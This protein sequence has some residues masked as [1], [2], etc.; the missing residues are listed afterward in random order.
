MGF[1]DSV[2]AVATNLVN[3]A[4]QSDEPQ[5]YAPPQN[6]QQPGYSVAHGAAPQRA[7]IVVPPAPP[8]P[9]PPMSGPAFGPIAGVSLE[10]YAN[11]LAL[12][13]DFGEDRERCAAI[14]AAH[15]V[16]REAWETAKDG[17]TARMADAALENR[18][19]NGFL[20]FYGPALHRKRGGR[21]PMSIEQYVRLFAETSFRKDPNDSSKQ[22]DREVVV[23]EHGITINQWNEALVY[24]SPR[25]SNQTDPVYGIY[26]QLLKR[27]MA[28]LFS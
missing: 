22:I 10:T 6:S 24:W 16:S 15:G 17:W 26:Q 11:L 18:V 25:V 19:S 23:A 7:P 28:R 5:S 13:S 4:L 20:H 3:Q 12:M 1:W 8:A 27:E 21:E 9:A 2:K 14:A